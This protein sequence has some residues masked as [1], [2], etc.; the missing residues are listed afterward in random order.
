MA[1]LEQAQTRA[2]AFS[3]VREDPLLDLAVIDTCKKPARILMIASGGCTAASILSTSRVE[4]LELVD[5]N[6]AQL[7]LSQAKIASL[8]LDPAQRQ[9]IFLDTFTAQTEHYLESLGLDSQQFGTES[10]LNQCGRYEQLFAHFRQRLRAVLS[11]PAEE[12][13][14]LRLQRQDANDI[15]LLGACFQEVFNLDTLIALFGHEACNNARLPFH[16]HFY[17]QTLSCFQNQL[18][19]DNYFLQDFFDGRYRQLP[20]SAAQHH[21]TPKR[22]DA[23]TRRRPCSIVYAKLS[24]NHLISSTCQTFS[25]G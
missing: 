20:L 3:Q 9:A 11:S 17:Q 13:L 6:P 1:W 4:T 15:K 2:V 10:S 23:A 14:S 21:Q 7:H 18:Y 16:Q 5:P 25:T 22:R 8:Q 19:K 12:C 24:I